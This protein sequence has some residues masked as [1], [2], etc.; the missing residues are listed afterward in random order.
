MNRLFLL[1]FLFSPATGCWLAQVANSVQLTG[2]GNV[3]TQKYDIVDFDGVHAENAFHVN[4]V[5][6]DGFAVEVQADDN[7]M[8]YVDVSQLGVPI[9][10][11]SAT[12]RLQLAERDAEGP[13]HDAP[14]PAVGC[15]RCFPNEFRKHR[16]L[17]AIGAGRL[18]CE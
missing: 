9:E 15:I 2:S 12:R 4:L 6:G 14:R 13:D 5:Q 8:P 7:V 17:G 16:R 18:W 10:T 11:P 1:A 3:I